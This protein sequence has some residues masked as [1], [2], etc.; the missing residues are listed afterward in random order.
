MNGS[1]L[2]KQPAAAPAA[3]AGPP[4][5]LPMI[6]LGIGPDSTIETFCPQ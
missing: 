2:G 5:D 6:Y 3:M 1:G 4:A